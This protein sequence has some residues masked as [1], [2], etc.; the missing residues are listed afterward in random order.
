MTQEN[1]TDDEFIAQFMGGKRCVI[2]VKSI[3]NV[4]GYE[5]DI[6]GT[7]DHLTLDEYC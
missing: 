2:Y 1:K 3:G 6:D 5:F 4:F 7:A